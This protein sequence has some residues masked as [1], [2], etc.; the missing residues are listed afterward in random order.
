MKLLQSTYTDQNIST[1]DLLTLVSVSP[2]FDRAPLKGHVG[3]SGS[4]P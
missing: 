4:H 1:Y 2:L 3:A